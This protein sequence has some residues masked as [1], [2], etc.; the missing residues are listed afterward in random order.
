MRNTCPKRNEDDENNPDLDCTDGMTQTGGANRV[1]DVHIHRTEDK[2]ALGGLVNQHYIFPS[3]IDK[4]DILTFMSNVRQQA[5]EHIKERC[6]QLKH[7]KWYLNIQV[8]MQRI[9]DD[10]QMHESKP[11]FRSHS[12]MLL[13]ADQMS[14]DDVDT[15]FQVIYKHFD[16]YNSMGSGWSLK[17]ILKLEIHTAKYNPLRARRHFRLPVGVQNRHAVINIQNQDEKCFVWCIL[18]AMHPAKNHPERVSHYQSYEREVNMTGIRFPVTINDIPKFEKQNN[19]SVT[20][21]G[22][23]DEDNHFFPMYV[24]ELKEACLEVDL[25]YVTQPNGDAHYALIKSMNK[26]LASSRSRGNAYHFCRYCLQGFT[27]ERVLR[28]H[29][30]YCATYECQYT[31]FPSEGVD[32]ILRFEDV[33]KQMRVGFCIYADM[34]AFSKPM[35]QE[36]IDGA[37]NKDLI[38][39]E[40]CS[41]GYQVVCTNEEFTKPPKLYRGPNV[42]DHFLDSL[43]EEQQY[44][45][46]ILSDTKDMILTTEEKERFKTSTKCYI[47]RRN[48]NERI[49][50][51]RDHCHITGKF[52][53]ASCSRCNLQFKQPNFIPVV[54]HNLKNFDMHL[55]MSGIGKWK[56]EEIKC[57]P[58]SSERFLSISLGKLRFIDSFQFLNESLEK[59][60]NNLS[61][62][63]STKE[64]NIEPFKRLR[65][66]FSCDQEARMLVRKGI[67]CYGHLDSAERFQEREL[68]PQSTFFNSLTDNHCSKEDYDFAKKVWETFN[69]QTFGDYHD[70]YLKTDVLLL[71]D[72]F[73][74]FRDMALTNYELDPAH[75]FSCPGLA[76]QSALK[77][78][79]CQLELLTDSTQYLFLEKGIRGGVSTVTKRFARANNKE[80]EDYDVSQTSNYLFLVDCN[81]LYG[82][83]MSM[84]LPYS[85]FKWV[86]ESQIHDIDFQNVP[87]D[88]ETGFVVECDLEYGTH[89]HDE[90]SDYPL[91]PESLIVQNDML[92]EH[93]EKIW[94]IQHQRKNPLQGRVK[95]AKLVPTLYDKTR[96]IVHYRV[97]KLYFQLGMKIKKV[98]KVLEFSQRDFL[99]PYIM[100]N[101]RRRSQ[102]KNDW[103][104]SFYKLMNNAVF[105]KTLENLRNRCD[106]RLVHTNEKFERLVAKTQFKRFEIINEDLVMI[107]LA[108]VRLHMNKPVAIGQ[109]I[110]DLSKY[111]MYD[112]HYLYIKRKFKDN[113][114]LCFTDTD[115]FLYDIKCNDLYEELIPDKHLFDFSNYPPAHFLHSTT[116]KSVLG[117]FKDE[118]A[119]KIMLRFCGLRSKLYAYN[120][121]GHEKDICKAK[122]VVKATIQKNLRLDLYEECLASHQTKTYQMNL[123]Q[124]S[125]HVLTL[126]ECSKLALSAFD[127]K[128]FLLD[129][130]IHTL[131]F[132]HYRIK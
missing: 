126:R 114:E 58:N 44:I 46:D 54:F 123:I 112:F 73:E 91:A 95:N 34:E 52:R 51:V 12:S 68:P 11:H 99:K 29:Q 81:N 41:Y 106:V 60:V 16:E 69:M 25:L 1:H 3:E 56:D 7:L 77:M 55:L 121:Q 103:E 107:E 98:H 102:A 61:N 87:D 130:G 116:N 79:Q 18:A 49:G 105:G 4:Y 82:H 32:D 47:C 109:A 84:K 88:G 53:G 22:Y 42:V 50:K 39:F 36:T 6:Q 65:A 75:F 122:G 30:Q 101:T 111:T 62:D 8:V 28:N 93:S 120:V 90:H 85:D 63:Q 83:S 131:A 59:L 33:R 66:E 86:E 110:L 9:R 14:Q 92:S 26:L 15:S 115:S 80:M 71:A 23:E 67:F 64:K 108:K 2:Q 17:K 31:T 38:T 94:R 74:N 72:V 70:L 48:F 128:R 43:H 21:L 27:S 5:M 97:L 37:D 132:G 96:Y 35:Q 10:G 118:C 45:E 89:L 19:I 13:N 119:S 57:I 117:K 125:N 127:D 104:K 124:S 24:S 78:T 76:W 20:V 129:D 100:M 113:V 40:A